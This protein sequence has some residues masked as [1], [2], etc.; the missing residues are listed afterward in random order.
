MLNGAADAK[1]EIEFWRDGLA[2]AANLALHGKPAFIANGARRGNLRAKSYRKRFRLRNVFGSF[3]AAAHGNNERRQSE[4]DR[5][6]DFRE[7][8]VR[9]GPHFRRSL[10]NTAGD[11]RST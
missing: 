8:L 9:F 4:V 10:V 11:Q 3:D 7:K 6:F 2:G 1:R 5:G